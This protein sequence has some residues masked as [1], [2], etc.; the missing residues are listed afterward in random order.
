MC[1]TVSTHFVAAHL[2]IRSLIAGVL[3]CWSC[4]AD[5]EKTL[6][7]LSHVISYYHV[8]EE[9]DLVIREE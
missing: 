7:S 2:A 3:H 9:V 4:L 6:S 5:I 8:A 1:S